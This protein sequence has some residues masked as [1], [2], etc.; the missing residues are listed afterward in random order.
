MILSSKTINGGLMKR[1]VLQG[2]KLLEMSGEPNAHQLSL[3]ARVTY[4]TVD[5]YVNKPGQTIA[6]D[7]I[8]LTQILIDGLDL[9]EDQILN[10]KIGDIFEII[11]VIK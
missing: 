9:T 7:T 2:K 1:L 8:S 4:P 6:Y 10:L 11:D 3:K 5:K